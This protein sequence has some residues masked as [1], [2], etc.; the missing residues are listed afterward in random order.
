M[1]NIAATVKEAFKNS[2]ENIGFVLDGAFKKHGNVSGA[3]GSRF[4]KEEYFKTQEGTEHFLFFDTQNWEIKEEAGNVTI[5]QAIIPE[6][7]AVMA[8]EDLKKLP[9][10]Q[11][12]KVQQ[13]GAHPTLVTAG[14]PVPTNKVT[15]IVEKDAGADPDL[16]DFPQLTGKPIMATWFPGEPLPPSHPVNCKEGDFLTVSEALQKG[17]N[18]VCLA[19]SI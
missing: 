3:T 19:E 1:K 10:D 12:C 7:L 14:E 18:T 15:C 5:V 6:G 4:V 17:W 9:A 2:K 8:A 11:L 16:K 13:L